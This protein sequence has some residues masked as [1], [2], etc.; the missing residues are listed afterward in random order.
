MEPARR[1]LLV[2]LGSAGATALAGCTGR[3][4]GGGAAFAAS[5]AALPPD[6]QR[7]TGYTHHR[8]DDATTSQRF[9]RFGVDRTVDVTNVVSE[10]DRAVE[11]ALLGRRL[12]A[13][14][15]A[16]LA[17]PKVRVL[18]REYN[19]VAAMS[20]A[21]IAAMVQERYDDFDVG[22]ARVDYRWAVASTGTTVT[23]FDAEAQLLAVGRP[24][25]VHLYVSRAVD[26]AGDFVVTLAVHP[27]AFGRQE[28]TVGRLM[29]AV[30]AG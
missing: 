9:S 5:G 28:S 20:T 4:T 18:G 26:A 25:D 30:R 12:Q 15:F 14:V 27:R 22:A 2:G 16:T 1:A 6:V 21:E 17:T 19:P 3:L 29:A 13:A 10:Y 11:V 8:T 7:E 24:V 23:R